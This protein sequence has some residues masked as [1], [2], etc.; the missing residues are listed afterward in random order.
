MIQLL[1]R[2]LLL[3]SLFSPFLYGS[4]KF[5]V[6]AIPYELLPADKVIREISTTFE[7]TGISTAVLK[8]K[9][10]A[11]IFSK[12][13]EAEGVLVLWYDKYL[14]I[15]ELDGTVY[16]ANG[17]EI[18]TLEDTDIQ[19]VPVYSGST[20]HSD[21]RRRIASLFHNQ[22]PYTVEFT[23]EVE[24]SGSLNWPEWQAQ[25]STDPVEKTSFTVICPDKYPLRFWCNKANNRPDI[26]DDG[27]EKVYQWSANN[28]HAVDEN[29]VGN[30]LFDVT[31]VVK[32]A[33]T[34]FQMDRYKGSMSS[35]KEFGQWIFDL[36]KTQGILPASATGEITSVIQS[37]VTPK[38]KV[39]K[40]YEYMQSRTRYVS[41]QLG[42]GGWQ[43]F[44]ATAVHTKG[45]G[46]CKALVNYMCVLLKQAGIPS[47]PV[48]I[49]AG[50]NA[51]PIITEFSSNQFN[52][53][54]LCVPQES[55][56]IWLECTSQSMP[57][58]RL[59]DF[60]EDREALLLTP[61]GGKIVR[62]PASQSTDNRLNRIASVTIQENGTAKAVVSTIAFG[63]QQAEI[64]GALINASP[65]EKER[66]MVQRMKMPDVSLSSFTIVGLENHA[67][68]ITLNMTAVLPRYAS[69]N[70]SRIFF[71][72]N[73]LAKTVYLPPKVEQRLSSVN[74]DYA[75]V[76]FDSIC[77][78]IPNGFFPETLPKEITL[79]TSFGSYSAG[80]VSAHDTALLYTRRIEIRQPLIPASQY[81]EYRDFWSEI[82]KSD[83]AQVV[84]K[85]KE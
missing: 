46:D 24:F 30:D 3:G 51:R 77:Y 32:I 36:Y 71:Y 4:G 21:A 23:Y 2:S 14:S 56:S 53:A 83:R 12:N 61:E 67:P 85:K 22:Y 80:V 13:E 69:A 72:P 19:D 1:L 66:W 59:S 7:I 37:A 74:I 33:P 64:Q 62:T 28:L 27:D 15:E 65:D 55:D 34:N 5:P 79:N 47:Y 68:E 11:T 73:L 57:F 29:S 10:V 8:E 35:W 75:Y 41:I 25:R 42:I 52:H 84:L 26:T 43:P 20:L 31:T 50:A 9:Y 60:T 58:G 45:Y 16:D 81:S 17:D 78:H 49:K 40:L 6:A 82:T 48:I 63:N 76:D 38:E 54:I 18:K 39:K 70:K 44:D